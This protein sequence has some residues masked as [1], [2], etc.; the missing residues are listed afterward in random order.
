MT[1][2]DLMNRPDVAMTNSSAQLKDLG[3]AHNAVLAA[4]QTSSNGKKRSHQEAFP[5]VVNEPTIDE[6]LNQLK[7]RVLIGESLN[8]FKREVSQL[9]E[10]IEKKDPQFDKLAD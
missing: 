3:A 6:V 9:V 8:N 1:A 10:L 2:T 7:E 4:Q 5:P